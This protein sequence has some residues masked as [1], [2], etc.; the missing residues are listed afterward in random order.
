MTYTNLSQDASVNVEIPLVIGVDVGAKTG[1]NDCAIGSHVKWIF[2]E[3]NFSAETITNAKTIHWVVRVIPATASASGAS[4]TNAADKAYVIKRG[5]EM[6]P[7]DLSVVYKRVFT[8]KIPRG[9]QRI[10]EGM[11]INFEYKASSTQTINSCGIF[12]YKELY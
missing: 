12:I 7:K 2:C 9:Y 8:V 6:L 3:F 10:K 5:M 1:V 11:K 4:T